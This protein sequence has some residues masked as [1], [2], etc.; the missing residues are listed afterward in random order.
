MVPV[1]R[2]ARQVVDVAPVEVELLHDHVA[3][4][5][6][7]VDAPAHRG[8]FAGEARERDRSAG[9]AAAHEL[10]VPLV[11]AR[12][13]AA[14]LARGERV[15]ELLHRGKRPRRGAR[16]FVR[17]AGDAIL[18]HSPRARMSSIA[19]VDPWTWMARNATTTAAVTAKNLSGNARTPF[20]ALNGRESIV[21][22]P[23]ARLGGFR[24]TPG[25]AAHQVRALTPA[26]L[27][28]ARARRLCSR[29]GGETDS[30]GVL[31]ASW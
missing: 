30:T 16:K 8:A 13:K 9:G 6:G 22:T 10:H 5:I 12:A 21:A 20:L 25:R 29:A 4:L 26:P 11:D 28:R 24:A 31:I 7:D 1:D 2:G 18:S 19:P 3:G 15:H 17:P 27:N 14:G 23:R